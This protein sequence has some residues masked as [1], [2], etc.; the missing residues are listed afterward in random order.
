M[1]HEKQLTEFKGK[2]RAE[3]EKLALELRAKVWHYRIDLAAGKTKNIKEIQAAKKTIARALTV[4]S[5]LRI[6]GK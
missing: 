5:G 6:A 3:L 4:A 2:T 1:K